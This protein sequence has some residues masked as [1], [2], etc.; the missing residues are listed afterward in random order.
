MNDSF[1]D[2]VGTRGA[3]LLRFAFVLCGDRHLAEDLVQDV[4]AKMHRRWKTVEAA[5]SP[6]AYVRKSIVHEFLSWRRRL[7]SREVSVADLPEQ[8]ARWHADSQVQTA[9]RDEMWRLLAALPRTQRVVLVLRFYEDLGYDEIS[10]VLGCAEATV[11]V[12]TSRGLAR[13]RVQL[14]PDMQ[15][16]DDVEVITFGG[17]A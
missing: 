17:A 16:Q 7:I 4:L 11:R 15:I 14:R 1:S 10:R 6:D 5:E 13:L 9:S 8:H 2:Y 3:A 12:H